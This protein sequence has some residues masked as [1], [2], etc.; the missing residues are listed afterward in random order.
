MLANAARSTP[1]HLHTQI[2]VPTLSARFL[3]T[4]SLTSSSSS[5]RPSIPYGV[6]L[7]QCLVEY[8]APNNESRRPLFNA[9]K[10]ASSFPVIFLS[11]AQRI[12]V[13]DTLA[14]K[15]ESAASQPW[16]GEHQLFRL[17]CVPLTTHTR[18]TAPTHARAR[19]RPAGSSLLQST[20]STRS[21]GT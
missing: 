12:V 1:R 8:N 21:G 7:R 11:A 10:Y 4:E 5:P 18:A 15:G 13:S 9:L 3:T 2:L 14:L 6:R 20:P 17:W 19:A 16:H